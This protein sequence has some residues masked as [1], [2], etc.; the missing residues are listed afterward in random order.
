MSAMPTS[1]RK[2]SASILTVGWRSMKAW[3]PLAATSMMPTEITTA[4]I[5]TG[6]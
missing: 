2:L 3:M 6:M 4:R 1:T 5:M